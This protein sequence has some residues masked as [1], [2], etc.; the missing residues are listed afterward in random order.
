[1]LCAAGSHSNK[2]SDF[3]SKSFEITN[4]FFLDGKLG[5]EACKKKK[6]AANVNR[7]CE[8]YRTTW[9]AKCK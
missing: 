9:S 2:I 1:M 6:R 3:I 7:N 5:F 4:L 8:N